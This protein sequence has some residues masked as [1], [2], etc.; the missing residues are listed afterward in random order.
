M[1]ALTAIFVRVVLAAA[2]SLTFVGGG[3][4]GHFVQHHM[5]FAHLRPRLPVLVPHRPRDKV[6][7][8]VGE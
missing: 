4:L 6:Q 1:I 3:A 2:V 8:V 5:A 7:S